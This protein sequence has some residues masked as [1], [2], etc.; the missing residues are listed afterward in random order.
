MR[1]RGV[2]G[3]A[4]DGCAVGEFTDSVHGIH[5]ALGFV[6]AVQDRAPHLDP[7]HPTVRECENAVIGWRANPDLALST[8]RVDPDVLVRMCIE[9]TRRAFACLVRARTEAAF[10]ACPR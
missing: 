8:L 2:C 10:A 7:A 9:V 6:R 5:D 1:P 4:L 3:A